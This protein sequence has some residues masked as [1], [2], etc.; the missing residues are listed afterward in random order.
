MRESRV[1]CDSQEKHLFDPFA[2][3]FKQQGRAPHSISSLYTAVYRRNTSAGVPRHRSGPPATLPHGRAP[4]GV[5]VTRAR[6]P[7][8]AA[9]SAPGRVARTRSDR[10]SPLALP[11]AATTHV[12]VCA[13]RHT[14]PDGGLAHR[15]RWSVAALRIPALLTVLGQ[16][17]VH[18][19][20]PRFVPARAWGPDRSSA[21]AAAPHAKLCPDF[22]PRRPPTA[23]RLVWPRCAI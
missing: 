4:R 16:V 18:T 5:H 21:A 9:A 10:L 11:A 15:G 14:W 19:K 1:R 7:A 8:H 23:T 22:A 20:A 17:L 2:D 6:E 3:L 13:A 12:Y